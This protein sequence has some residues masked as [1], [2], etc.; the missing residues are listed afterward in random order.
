[1][2]LPLFD[3]GCTSW[4]PLLSKTMK[5]K[6]QIAQNKWM[7]FAWSPHLVVICPSHFAKINWPLIERRVELCTSTSLF[8]YSEGIPLSYISYLFMLSLNN[9]NNRSQMTLD[10]PLFRAYKG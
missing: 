8:K 9:C 4:Y 10:K 5:I 6:S 7:S 1:M 2:T 3:Y